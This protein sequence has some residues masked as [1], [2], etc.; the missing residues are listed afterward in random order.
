MLRL[1]VILL[2]NAW[3]SISFLIAPKAACA[4]I[5]E[6]FRASASDGSMC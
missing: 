3:S 5:A 6:H 1:L 4:F 2:L